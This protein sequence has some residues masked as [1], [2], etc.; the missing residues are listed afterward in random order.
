[1]YERSNK[2]NEKFFQ[3]FLFYSANSRRVGVFFISNADF[4]KMN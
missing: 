2:M 4:I 1:M 3:V